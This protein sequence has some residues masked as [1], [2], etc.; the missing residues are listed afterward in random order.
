M[1]LPQK[2]KSYKEKGNQIRVS[3]KL[4]WQDTKLP[5]DNSLVNQDFIEM[6]IGY[7]V[8]VIF[9]TGLVFNLGIG[10]WSRCRSEWKVPNL[11]LTFV[12]SNQRFKSANSMKSWVLLA[13]C[14]CFWLVL[15]TKTWQKVM[16]YKLGDWYVVCICPLTTR[17]PSYLFVYSDFA[18][19]RKAHVEWI[20][21][22][23]LHDPKLG[24]NR[25]WIQGSGF[26]R[27]N[28]TTIRSR[29]YK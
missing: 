19:R 12:S 18:F 5:V 22:D 29:R 17:I 8:V 13:L 3:E 16:D 11:S 20:C 28:I 9:W 1:T 4:K 26:R 24:I 7:I 6:R 23:V 27:R 2:S 21:V 15:I 10:R 25:L 14:W